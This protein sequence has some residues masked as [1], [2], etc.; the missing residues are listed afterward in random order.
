MSDGVQGVFNSVA[1]DVYAPVVQAGSVTGGVTIHHHGTARRPVTA[2]GR[3]A[4]RPPWLARLTSADGG[5]AQAGAL[6]DDRHLITS[7]RAAAGQTPACAAAPGAQVLV[8]FPFTG[9][10]TAHH[11]TTVEVVEGAALL[12]L[13]RPVPHTP[14]PLSAPPELYG[15]GFWVHGFPAGQP[16]ARQ[17]HGTLD[18]AAG[19]GGRWLQVTGPTGWRTDPGFAGSPVFDDDLDAVV[20]IIGWHDGPY[21]GCHVLPVSAWLTRWPFLRARLG[22]RLDLDPHLKTHWLPRARGSEV[23]SDSGAWYFTGRHAARQAVCDWLAEPHRPLLVVTGGPGTGKSA[24]LAHLLV[25][26]DPRWAG[27]VP[28]DGP[29]PAAGSFDAAVHMKGRTRDEVVELLGSL[30]DVR[31]GSQQELL[32]GLRE[33]HAATG[34]VFTVLA[35]A[36]EEAAGVEEATRI[37]RLLRELASTSAVRVAAAVR[38]AP[39]GTE[40]ARIMAAFGRTA[41]RIDLESREYQRNF[42]VADYVQRRLTHED[43]ESPRYRRRTEAETRAIGRAVARKAGYNFLIAQVTSRWL[44]LPDTPPLDLDDP[45]WDRALPETIGEAMEKYLDAFGDDKPL[46]ER[47]LTALAF[48]RGDGLPRGPGWLAVADALHPGHAHTGAELAKV[49]QSAANYLVERMTSADGEPAYRLY[50]D[51]LDEH[52]RGRCPERDPHRAIVTTLLAA[53]PAHGRGRAWADADHYT[54]AQLAVHAADVAGPDGSC[55]LDLLLADGGFLG[56]AVPSPLL[57]VLPR[58]G[59]EEGRLAAAVYRASSHK[60]RHAEPRTRC[61]LLAVDA[62][63]FG[64]HH[65]RESLNRALADLSGPARDLGWQVGFATG[66]K[67]HAANT[68]T[69]DGHRTVGVVKVVAAGAFDDRVLGVSGCGQGMV[70]AWDLTE[71]RP[72][73]DTFLAIPTSVPGTEHRKEITALA[74]A[75]LDGR[76]V[77]VSA[78]QDGWLR[79]WDLAGPQRIGEIPTG[80]GGAVQG[81][82]VTEL[83]GALVAVTLGKDGTLRMWDLAEQRACGGPFAGHRGTMTAVEVVD[84]DGGPVA[85]TLEM[86]MGPFR[87]GGVIRQWDLRAGAEIGAPMEI[88]GWVCGLAVAQVEGRPVALTA[89]QALRVWDL[90]RRRK[91][92]TLTRDDSSLVATTVRNGRP[93][94]VSCRS[95]EDGAGT[96]QVWDLAEHRRIGGDLTGHTNGIVGLATATAAGRPIAVTCGAYQN[97]LRLWDL[98]EVEHRRIGAPLEGHRKQTTGVAVLER[99][100]HRFAVTSSL[101]RSA[102][103]WDLHGARRAHA[104]LPVSYVYGMSTA[105]VRDEPSAIVCTTDRVHLWNLRTGR[106]VRFPLVVVVRQRYPESMDVAEIG[107]RPVMVGVDS[108]R[109]YTWDLTR[110]RRLTGPVDIGT[111]ANVRL[112]EIDGR[113][114]AVTA[115]VVDNGEAYPV[116]LWDLAA[117]RLIG[118]MGSAVSMALA[119]TE[120]HGRPAAVTAGA[121]GAVQ[122]WDLTAGTRIM[123]LGGGTAVFWYVV[124]GRL[125]DGSPVALTVGRDRTLRVWDLDARQAIEE[126]ALPGDPHGLAL[127]EEG[128]VALALDDDL[129]VLETNLTSTRRAPASAPPRG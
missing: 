119:V 74:V 7:A 35:D 115:G 109:L 25:S 36:V 27:E 38:T 15:H 63:R 76:P 87:Q 97:T 104:P 43:A 89:G 85:V 107:G 88:S 121:D 22:W 52:L 62:A 68:G 113:P 2:V 110:G 64:A 30:A 11:A 17:E 40:R 101:D 55:E 6:V 21:R 60:H 47:L 28:T 37:A 44:L 94:A 23:E 69:L 118:E 92:A 129:V 46:V 99:A 42:D 18:G 31:A 79:V 117:G 20:G 91:L 51:A 100:G 123:E 122:V 127:G 81:L 8:E 126:I 71:Q 98:G 116:R 82:A 124:T 77:A 59:T 84:I 24:L 1:A 128:T 103:A 14:A 125:P 34:E 50:H 65:L 111:K 3:L 45:E 9:E 120:L 13:D 108:D 105:M 29:R 39:A 57:A 80:Q 78:G 41:P 72:I 93:V 73:G 102:L 56:H 86:T 90:A 83:M 4:H 96:L 48:A 33:R 75:E 66:G 32:I 19:P 95:R 16:G 67:V 10:P 61:L 58:A 49:F 53:V 5:T 106:S 114:A 54:R 26:S 12:R 70:Q 112:V